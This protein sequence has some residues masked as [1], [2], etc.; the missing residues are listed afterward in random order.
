MTHEM[1][2][3]RANSLLATRRR[4]LSAAVQVA[5]AEGV[6]WRTIGKWLGVSG[7]AAQ[8]RFGRDSENESQYCQPSID[9]N[10]AQR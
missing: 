3:R 4:A 1:K 6:P 7:Q 2:I 5:R 10:D 8:Q 9:V